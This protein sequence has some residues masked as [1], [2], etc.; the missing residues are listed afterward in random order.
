[1]S[2]SME[3]KPDERRHQRRIGVEL[4]LAAARDQGAQATV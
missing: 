4:D 3:A 2:S 1:M